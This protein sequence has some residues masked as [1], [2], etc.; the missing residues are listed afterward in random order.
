MLK[1]K[2]ANYQKIK[3]AIEYIDESFLTQPSL[4]DIALHVGLSKFHFARVFKEY[5]GVTP[6]QFLQAVTLNHA[7]E[8]LKKSKSLLDSTYE[9]GLSS[10]SR[11]HE[12]F[13][14]FVGVTPKEYKQMGK[15]LLITYGF[16]YTPFGQALIGFTDRG[17][18]TLAFS[19]DNEKQSYETFCEFWINANLER[20]DKIAQEYLDKI[21]IDKEK[22]NLFVKGTNFQISVWQAL[23]NLPKGIVSS[24][25]DIAN[26]IDK[27]KAVRAVASAIG[28]NHIA[29]LI[30]CHRVIAKSGAM[31]GYR[32]GIE[33]KK[34]VLAYESFN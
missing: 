9:S 27:P 14:N 24:Y 19:E 2:S 30:P 5:A 3:Q 4:E 15:D 23:L 20:D 18:C 33:R 29:Y 26:F 16:G 11:L 17:V 12:L 34:I 22:F 25:Q 32:W 28:S 8:S 13:V 1:D 31:S 6:M 7:K 10:S 21:F